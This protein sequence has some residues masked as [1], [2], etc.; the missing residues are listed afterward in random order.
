MFDCKF[1]TLY[2]AIYSFRIRTLNKDKI[3]LLIVR[4]I[5]Y[6]DSNLFIKCFLFINDVFMQEIV[7]KKKKFD[8]LLL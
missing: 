6:I 7:F 2:I 3:Y 8:I 1:T 4:K 5:H